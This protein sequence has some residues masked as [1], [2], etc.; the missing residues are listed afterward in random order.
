[1]KKTLSVTLILLLCLI[2][3]ALKTIPL[4]HALG[5]P[6]PVA[7]GMTF[8]SI[9]VQT[10]TGTAPY[11]LANVTDEMG[12]NWYNST[13]YQYPDTQISKCYLCT[14]ITGT[15]IN[16][17]AVNVGAEYPG[18]WELNMTLPS[19]IGTI[20]QVGFYAES[21]SGLWGVTTFFFT[22][23]TTA[24]YISTSHDS[25]S[26]I[27]PSGL[28]AVIYDGSQ[29]YTF[30]ALSGHTIQAVLINNSHQASTTS[31]YLFKDVQQNESIAIS[32]S[33]I[34]YSVKA[35]SD[36]GCVIYPSGN[37]L[38]SFGSWANFTCLA[39]PGYEIYN[40]AVNGVNL[41]P[42]AV[43]DLQPSSNTT[44]YLT[45]IAIG[46]GGSG[47][48]Q[49]TT[50]S[51]P[52]V[53]PVAVVVASQDTFSNLAIAVVVA[54]VIVICIYAVWYSNKSPTVKDLWNERTL[55]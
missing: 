39:Y 9:P 31:P 28:T 22:I 11:T 6:A 13:T 38:Y 5:A 16:Y 17:T 40:L 47:S 44:L 41:G 51:A 45:S 29:S 35:S 36:S 21:T 26:T 43:Y 49:S 55:G 2:P 33:S 32:T 14:N 53:T 46:T 34:I 48:I 37:L 25:E 3:V 8:N 12:I 24:L 20:F 10:G 50:T 23:K 54:I 30:S 42:V 27:T 7:G 18:G 52:V 15:W 1:M 19:T 4:T